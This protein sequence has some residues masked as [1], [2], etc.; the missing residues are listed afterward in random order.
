MFNDTIVAQTTPPGTGGISIVRISGPGAS[1]I[2][3]KLTNK[4]EKFYIKK[5]TLFNIYS[6]QKSKIDRAMVTFYKGPHSYTGEDIVEVACHGNPIIVREIIKTACKNG[7]R[8]P[9]PGEFTMRS[10]LNGKMDLIQAEAVASL[11]GAKSL[12]A[13]KINNKVLSG[14]L[15]KHIKKLKDNLILLVSYLEYELDVSEK[16][17]SKQT[18]ST[19]YKLYKNSVLSCEKLLEN[20]RKEESFLAPKVVLVGEP[21]VGKSTLLNKLVGQER[22]IVSSEKGTTRDRIDV[23]FYINKTQATLIDTAG[24]RDSKNKV[25]LEGIK[26]TKEAIKTADL[27]VYV[28][29]KNSNTPKLSSGKEFILVFN[30]ADIYRKPVKFKSAISISALKNKNI[31]NLKKEIS[32]VLK[33]KQIGFDSVLITTQ[34]QFESVERCLKFLRNIET[35]VMKNIIYEPEI[36][37]LDIREGIKELDFLLGRTTPD[38]ILD[39]VFSNFC[40][41]K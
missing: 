19:I 16:N 23:P 10:F 39:S 26:R 4:K 24:I 14:G 8:S 13:A 15:S 41:G 29:S 32:N 21:N 33:K 2:G 18:A 28:V 22:A 31:K 9:N 25:E 3:N 7:A 20:Y 17:T 27:I 12:T 6:R 37:S 1:L 35:Y 40:V 11:I 5:P 30:K 36:V 34:R 38:D